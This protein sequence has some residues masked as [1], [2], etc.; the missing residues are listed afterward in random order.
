[1]FEFLL[2]GK[3]LLKTAGKSRSVFGKR[4]VESACVGRER[5]RVRESA[6][7]REQETERETERDRASES[8]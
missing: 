1:M 3:N 8:E 6:R 7:E 5:E 2:R 4:K